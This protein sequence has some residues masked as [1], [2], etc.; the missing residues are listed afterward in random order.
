MLFTSLVFLY[1]VD[2]EIQK[3]GGINMAMSVR[4]YVLD[5]LKNGLSDRL[6]ILTIYL[7]SSGRNLVKI[8]GRSDEILGVSEPDF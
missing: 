8:S 7:L 4:T 5:Y 1:V 6:E 3:K 2:V